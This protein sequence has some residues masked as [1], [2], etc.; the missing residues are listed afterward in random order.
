MIITDCT[1]PFLGAYRRIE[2]MSRFR[3]FVAIFA[4]AMTVA[5]T[6]LTGEV[7]PA[8]KDGQSGWAAIAM[9]RPCLLQMMC[10]PSTTFS[11]GIVCVAPQGALMGMARRSVEPGSIAFGHLSIPTR[12]SLH[13]RDM[14]CSANSP[15]L[16]GSPGST[17]LAYLCNFRL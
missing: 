13:P 12:T 14:N 6:P 8:A 7:C 17:P 11:S 2:E 3:Q 10:C 4:L 16:E 5:V 1:R 9:E 15:G